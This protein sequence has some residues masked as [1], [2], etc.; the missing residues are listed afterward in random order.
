MRGWL[1]AGVAFAIYATYSLLRWAQFRTAG[2][3][4]GIFDQVV[5]AY[6]RFQ[7]PI[8]TLKGDGYNIWG[9]HFHP[10]VALLAPLYWLWDDARM[11]LLGQ[12]A[13]IA[14]S[15]P[16]V[17]RFAARRMSPRLAT[18]LTIGYAF[19]WAIQ[20]MVD[21][22]FHEIAFGVPLL[23]VAIDALDRRRDAVL[24]ASGFALLLV[25]EDLGIVVML[26]GLVRVFR[27]PRWVGAVLLAVGPV[28]FVLITKVVIPHFAPSGQFAYWAYDALG[29]DAPSAIGYM[30]TH[31]ITTAVLFFAPPV[32]SLTFALFFVPTLFLGLRSPYVIACLPIL[33]QRFFASRENL[34]LPYFH[35]NAPVWVIVVLAAVDGV[36]R[37][38]DRWADRMKP[39]FAG[40]LAAFALVPTATSMPI[41]PFS[42]LIN[43][44][45]YATT[46]LMTQ[47]R[48]VLERIP[49]GTCV[50]ADDRLA[51]HLVRTNRVSLPGISAREPDFYA[52][53]LSQ[54]TSGTSPSPWPRTTYELSLDA[55]WVE[56]FR[57]G[58]VVLLRNPAYAGPSAECRPV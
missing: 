41:A 44:T 6:A 49:A 47:Q 15:I 28:A 24:M 56:Q 11:L 43:G 48:A 42:Q 18:W 46:E 12:T 33:A 37:L 53:D 10:I 57:A 16:V 52:L 21:F 45:I 30:V 5:R 40:S 4:L 31:P 19:G 20:T 9:D 39:L 17:Y 14:V 58:P 51:G 54:R 35:Y 23:A 50:G 22:D 36:G 32:K 29:K 34:W 8:V 1:I 55:G 38:T 3:D 26:L 27:R 25:R 7:A 13:L 2:Y